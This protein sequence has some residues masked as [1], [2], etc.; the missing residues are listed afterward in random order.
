M[1]VIASDLKCYLSGGASNADPDAALGGVIS[2]VEVDFAPTANNLFDDVSDVEAAAGDTEY[3]CFYVKNTNATDTLN[4]AAIY[5]QSNTPS[6]DDTVE[7]GL[8]P[9][10]IG[11]GSATGVATTAANE[12]TAPAGVTFSAAANSGA[13]LAIGTLDA[14]EAQAVWVRRTVTAGAGGLA[15]NPFTL[16]VTG[17]PA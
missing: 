4:T 1:A 6:A 17:T 3:R 13:A 14:G 9:A 15:S 2:S 7:I 5:I 11:D 8:D 10:G 12:S 16:R